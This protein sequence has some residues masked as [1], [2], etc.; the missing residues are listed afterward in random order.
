MVFGRC[1][2]ADLIVPAGRGL[3]RRAGVIS[4]VA[5]GAWVANISRTHALY[6]EGDGYRIRLPRLDEAG[7]EGGGGE[8][9]K[10][11][12][13]RHGTALVGS[14][15]MLDEGLPLR[16]VVGGPAEYRAYIARSR[17]EFMVPKQMYVDTNSGL[18]SDR[19][20][21]YL[22]S[23][24]PVLARD[25]GIGHLYPTGEGLLTFSTLEEAATGVEA[26]NRDY[27]RHA[28]AAREIAVEY[29]DSDKVL[30]RLLADLGVG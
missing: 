29:F 1:P 10:G 16:L 24:R 18:L 11:W 13:L 12:F 15:A 2:D 20:V 21:Y 8:P 28:K 5:D 25:T 19:S 27:G 30:A 17:A 4:A 23:G 22:A 3:S 14:R 6:A 7:D 26:I 9:S